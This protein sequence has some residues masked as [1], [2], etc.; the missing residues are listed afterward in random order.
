MN[1]RMQ[2]GPRHIGEGEPV[3]IIADIG[4]NHG[5]KLSQAIELIDIAAE[6]GADAVKLQFYYGASLWPRDSRAYPILRSL[7]TNREWLPALLDHARKRNILL[8]A[9]PFDKD[10]VDLLD[11][12]DTPLFK[13]ASSEIFDL[14]LLK[15][16]ARKKRPIILSTGVSTLADIEKA[17][18]TITR[19]GN[20][21]IVLLHCVSAYP[22]KPEDAHLRMM[23]TIKDAFQRPVGFSDHT[24]GI[25]IPLAAVARGACVIEKHF[26]V[27]RK[28]KGLD[29]IF[30]LE[31]HEL[32]QMV[33]GI[34][35]VERSLGSAVKEIVSGA[36]DAKQMVRLVAARDI[37]KG[38]RLTEDIIAVKRAG[39][40]IM[41][42]FFDV[43]LNRK[44]KKDLRADSPITWEAI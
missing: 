43:V 7:E 42:E 1:I 32:K 31:P 15:Y 30:A 36:E 3:F 11:K 27:S 38:T 44:A 10:A 9:T 29:H 26:T 28:M 33:Q 6:S 16:A 34:R 41:P 19:E 21:D 12:A 14:P 39:F 24:M 22:T 13:W 25:A 37:A 20:E 18:N 17:V 35:D 23:D 2:A 4:G 8:I 40:G 5:G